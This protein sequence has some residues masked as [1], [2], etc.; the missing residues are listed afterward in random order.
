MA[1]SS[2]CRGLLVSTVVDAIAM[3]FPWV[4]G[5]VGGWV[6]EWVGLG[7]GEG[8]LNELCWKTGLG[9]WVGGWVGG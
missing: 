9:G 7:R 5:W 2:S 3:N 1:G 6:G 4:G 8:C